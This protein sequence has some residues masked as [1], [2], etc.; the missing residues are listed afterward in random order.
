MSNIE[1]S[2]K[3]KFLKDFESLR[4][5]LFFPE[6]WTDEETEISTGPTKVSR[7]WAPVLKRT[8]F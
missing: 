3:G 8:L 7:E 5:D 1:K 6:T 2:D 4:P